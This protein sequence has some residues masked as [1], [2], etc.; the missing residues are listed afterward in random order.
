MAPTYSDIDGR[1][2]VDKLVQLVEFFAQRR[3]GIVVILNY[4][5][6][7]TGAFDDVETT[8][9]KL[10]VVFKKHGLDRVKMRVKDKDEYRTGYW[11][12]VDGAYGG[13]YLPH[14][15]RYYETRKTNPKEIVDKVLSE[16]GKIA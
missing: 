7:F 10:R 8:C 11:I 1:V 2:D 15:D 12:H 6:T 16:D 14:L 3:H 4:G 5:T 9:E 13:S